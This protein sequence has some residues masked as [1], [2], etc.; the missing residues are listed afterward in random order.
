[1]L[2]KLQRHA[3]DPNSSCGANEFGIPPPLI[4]GVPCVA[5]ALWKRRSS[6]SLSLSL[7]LAGR[8][9]Q[10]DRL[11]AAPSDLGTKA[12]HPRPVV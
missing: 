9:R 5:L 2:S 8:N 1:M 11:T 12:L 10:S 4:M 3:H 6:R 7:A